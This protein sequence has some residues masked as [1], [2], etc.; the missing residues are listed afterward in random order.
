[1]NVLN[2][3]FWAGF[4]SLRMLILAVL[5]AFYPLVSIVLL[6]VAILAA[7]NTLFMAWVTGSFVSFPVLMSLATATISAFLMMCYSSLLALFASD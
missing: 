3:M 1:M 4:H 5:S 7:F 2:K 6:L